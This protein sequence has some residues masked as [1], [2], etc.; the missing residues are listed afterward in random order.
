MSD[1]QDMQVFI[2]TF[3]ICFCGT[4]TSQLW[5]NPAKQRQDVHNGVFMPLRIWRSVCRCSLS[6]GC[7]FACLGYG[8][9]GLSTK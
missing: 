3:F 9:E 4:Q 2:E 7:L 8:S 1:L 5:I 6:V